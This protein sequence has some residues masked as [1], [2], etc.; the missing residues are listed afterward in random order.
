MSYFERQD[1]CANQVAKVEHICVS[2]GSRVR[3]AA[4][5]GDLISQR[6]HAGKTW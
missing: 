6:L 4:R 1:E 5:N 2:Q 3:E